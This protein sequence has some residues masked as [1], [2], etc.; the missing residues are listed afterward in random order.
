METFFATSQT[1]WLSIN[2]RC[3]IY[4]WICSITL[5]QCGYYYIYGLDSPVPGFETHEMK[6][7][8]GQRDGEG[9][10]AAESGADRNVRTH[11]DVDG[12]QLKGFG[13]VIG[14][15]LRQVVLSF[16]KEIS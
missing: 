14:E 9:G 1:P 8:S 13:A 12:R 3:Y 4:L 2:P 15:V 5:S 16:L 6:N 10:R 11:R 7:G